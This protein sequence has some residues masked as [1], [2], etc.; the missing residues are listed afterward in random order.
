MV[1]QVQNDNQVFYSGLDKVIVDE[2][3]FMSRLEYEREICAIS[4]IDT[5][6]SYFDIAEKLHMDERHIYRVHR[7]ALQTAAVILADQG[8]IT[9]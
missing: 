8:K 1:N 6:D 4:H 7:K 5:M 2:L 3:R 9:A